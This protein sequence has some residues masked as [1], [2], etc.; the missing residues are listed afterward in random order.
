MNMQMIETIFNRDL[1][2]IENKLIESDL[3]TWLDSW[4][5]ERVAFKEDIHE[6]N[7]KRYMRTLNL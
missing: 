7:H 2:E 4:I 1:N 3:I 6:M 5:L